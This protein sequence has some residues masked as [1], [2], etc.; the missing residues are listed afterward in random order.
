LNC[1]FIA[2]KGIAIL[3]LRPLASKSGDIVSSHYIR[4]LATKHKLKKVECRN[5]PSRA[6]GVQLSYK[7]LKR[8]S[9]V[10]GQIRCRIVFWRITIRPYDKFIFLLLVL[11]RAGQAPPL[12]QQ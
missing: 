2:L 5:S 1:C 9:G 8:I 3:Q 6:K 12:Q 10:V 7:Q 11:F 4:V